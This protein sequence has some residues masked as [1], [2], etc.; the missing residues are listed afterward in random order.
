M[1]SCQD[2]VGAYRRVDRRDATRFTR[3]ATRTANDPYAGQTM[4]TN[5]NRPRPEEGSAGDEVHRLED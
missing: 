4:P 3:E 2:P 1:V 5:T